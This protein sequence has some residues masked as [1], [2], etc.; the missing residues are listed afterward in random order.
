MM[1]HMVVRAMKKNP[2]V[3]ESKELELLGERVAMI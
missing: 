1:K 3:G 2:L